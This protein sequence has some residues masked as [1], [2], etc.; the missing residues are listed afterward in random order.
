VHAPKLFALPGVA[1]ASLEQMQVQAVE[2]FALP[3]VAGA[4]SGHA[5]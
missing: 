5:R 1:G 4:S 3:G 2:L